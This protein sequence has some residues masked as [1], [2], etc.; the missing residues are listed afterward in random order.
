MRQV[1]EG[2]DSVAAKWVAANPDAPPRTFELL[3]KK[4]KLP[5]QDNHCDC[6]L[7]LLTYLDFFTHGLPD[8]LR[9]TIRSNRALDP[10]EILGALFNPISF[11]RLQHTID[12]GASH[13]SMHVPSQLPFEAILHQS[14]ASVPASADFMKILAW[15]FRGS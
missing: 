14:P 10:S 5:M 3:A 8:N 11:P 13:A 15:E 7:F 9:L 6:G 2:G 1:S 4:V 12:V